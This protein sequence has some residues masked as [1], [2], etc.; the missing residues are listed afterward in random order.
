MGYAIRFS[1][2]IS[3]FCQNFKKFKERYAKI[4]S[5][6]HNEYRREGNFELLGYSKLPNTHLHIVLK[7]IDHFYVILKHFLEK[8]QKKG[9]FHRGLP[10]YDLIPQLYS[11]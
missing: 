6:F 5:F 2:G 8:K 9:I 1:F 10:N 11:K 3:I 7:K 4:S